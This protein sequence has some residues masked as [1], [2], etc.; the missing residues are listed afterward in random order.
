[1]P[2]TRESGAELTALSNNL[3]D[4][5]DRAGRAVVAIHARSRIPASGIVWRKGVIVA[6]D[7]T[8]R[9]DEDIVVTLSDGS[10]SSAALAGRD[11][12]T[13]LAVLKLDGSTSAAPAKIDDAATLKAGHLV[14]ALGR[15]GA[16]LTASLGLVSLASGEWRSWRGGKI[17]QYIL[18]DVAIHDGFSGGPLIDVSGNVVGVNTS[19]LAR[20]RAMA[21][22][23]RTANRVVDQLLAKGRIARGYLGLA[24]QPVRLPADLASTLA[25]PDAQALIIVSVEP[26]GPGADA[27]LLLGDVLVAANGQSV[28]DARDLLASLGPE[29]IGNTL[30]VRVIR[31]GVPRDLEIKVRERS[32]R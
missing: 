16:D 24:M 22:P 31:G 21:V 5:V 7:H 32:A 4:A 12:T 28:R 15:P 13:D 1:M 23:V 9:R 19:G 26:G 18:L 3:A 14:L 11:P 2:A 17:D 6:A 8:I 20:G 25:V 10:R 30:R 27:G 29:S